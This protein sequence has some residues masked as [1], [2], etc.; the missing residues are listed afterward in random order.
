MPPNT[1]GTN[2][3]KN[4]LFDPTYVN[5]DYYFN[6]VLVF[7]RWVQT[8]H[9]G[10]TIYFVSYVLTLVRMVEI[11]GEENHH[12]KHAIAEYAA[13]RNEESSGTRNVRW[14]HIQELINSEN[15][16]DWRLA[17][18]EADSVLETLLDARDLPGKG[19][20]E[21]LKN[22]SPGD[23]GSMQAAWEAHLVRNKIAHDGSEF[24]LSNREARRT[25][26]LF[27]VVF[28]ELGFL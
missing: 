18:I 23:L 15:P 16:S 28:R 24:D 19:I 9:L 17:I 12:L 8:L 20:G 10:G 25:V 6:Q 2:L 21:K 14:E 22:I 13:R 11:A 27:E 5:I 4:P 1:I 3:L 7:F 26:Q